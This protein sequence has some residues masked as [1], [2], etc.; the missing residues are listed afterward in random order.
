MYALRAS[1]LPVF[2]GAVYVLQ[3]SH[4]PWK[5]RVYAVRASVLSVFFETVYELQAS[6]RPWQIV[7]RSCEQTFGQWWTGTARGDT[8]PVLVRCCVVCCCVWLKVFMVLG[9]V[10]ARWSWLLQRALHLVACCASR[11][12]ARAV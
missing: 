11:D 7:I 3:D 10:W 9:I 2:F 8:Q 4:R 6:C 1:V 5:R 12:D